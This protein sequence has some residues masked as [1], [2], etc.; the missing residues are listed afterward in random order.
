M[1]Q[2]RHR[3]R[4][5]PKA[6]LFLIMHCRARKTAGAA[7][8]GARS[9]LHAGVVPPNKSARRTLRP[10]GR[11][12]A[13]WT[14]WEGAHPARPLATMW[15]ADPTEP[16]RASARRP[17]SIHQGAVGIIGRIKLICSQF[18]AAPDKLAICSPSVRFPFSRRPGS[19]S[20]ASCCATKAVRPPRECSLSPFMRVSCLRPGASDSGVRSAERSSVRIAR[21]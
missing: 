4:N 2:R 9:D 16:K 1:E 15:S 13:A 17:N 5:P 14:W 10:N 21:A 12:W 11:A 3:L 8:E 20:N 19:G 6:R 7:Q 18:G